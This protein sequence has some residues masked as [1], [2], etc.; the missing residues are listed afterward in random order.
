MGTAWFNEDP[1]I[2]TEFKD[3]KI[4]KIPKIIT[5]YWVDAD[6]KKTT[7]LPYGTDKIGIYIKG[8][9]LSGKEAKIKVF[10]S[11]WGMFDD[12]CMGNIVVDFDSDEETTYFELTAKIFEKGEKDKTK[13]KEDYLQLY[14]KIQIDE[15]I[16][17]E[18]CNSVEEQLKVH[19]V[20]Y[21]PRAMRA[22]DWHMGAALQEEWFSRKETET[23]TKPLQNPPVIDLIKMEWV[24][25]FP[26]VKAVYDSILEERTWINEKAKNSLV[27]E[28][29]RMNKEGLITLPTK[30]GE[31]TDF[32]VFDP[33]LVTY[34]HWKDGIT[35]SPIYD[36]YYYQLAEHSESPISAA[37]NG[38]EALDDLFAAL[39]DFIFRIIGGGTITKKG[40]EYVIR[41][42]KLGIYVRDNFDFNDLWWTPN[43]PL[44]FWNIK[45][46]DIRTLPAPGY[47]YIS[48]ESYRDYREEFE[49][50]EDFTVYSDIKYEL[51][52]GSFRILSN[53]LNNE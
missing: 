15:Q 39:G 48:N 8:K 47:Y 42:T 30:E 2:K 12:D 24:L 50:G 37:W 27:G 49:M 38:K 19:A 52:N 1:D 17:E 16:D 40:K 4:E 14:F 44:G 36:K 22:Q 35:Q 29:K 31:N 43:Q 9:N 53:E 28:L 26:R 20:R 41:I 3:L 45:E 32:G 34:K 13:P 33:I 6:G 46:K 23:S 21:I 18:F 51:V 25:S 10:D 5:A 11:D 7:K